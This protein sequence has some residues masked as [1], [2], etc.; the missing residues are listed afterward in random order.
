MRFQAKLAKKLNSNRPGCMFR[1]T[2]PRHTSGLWF[3]ET[4]LTAWG[5]DRD[6]VVLVPP[7]RARFALDLGVGRTAHEHLRRRTEPGPSVPTVSD[8]RSLPISFRPK[9][10]NNR[11]K[12]APDTMKMDR[13]GWDGEDGRGRC[14]GRDKGKVGV[15]VRYWLSTMLSLRHWL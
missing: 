9:T 1:R 2:S 14:R 8:L 11:I 12:A 13:G 5:W 10:V 6:F 3:L 4:R 15:G 7:K